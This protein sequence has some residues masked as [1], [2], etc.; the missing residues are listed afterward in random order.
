VLRLIFAFVDIMLHRRG[1][2][3]LPSSS[4]LFWSLLALSVIAD[5]FVIWLAGES[6]RI[7]AVALLI[8]FF[9]LWFVWALLRA[10]GRQQRFRQTM[11]AILGAEL[12]LQ[13]LGAPLVRPL[14]NAPP[15]DPA[16]PTLTFIGLLALLIV[17]W[18][19]DITSFVFSRA[20]ERPYLLCLA[21]VIGYVLLMESLRVTIS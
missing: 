13:V 20:L 7:F 4:F 9:D 19:I 18:S 11:T 8:T 2:D 3:S 16:N 12:L 5:G 15:P 10:F 1:P 21:I 14:T 6:A 17:V